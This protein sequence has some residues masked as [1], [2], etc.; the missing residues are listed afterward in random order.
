MTTQPLDDTVTILHSAASPARVLVADDHKHV[1]EALRLLLK[2]NRVAVRAVSS[3]AAVLTALR[4]RAHEPFDLLLMDLN[5]ARDTT[6]GEE[7]I[8]LLARV[9]AIDPDLPI[10]VMTAWSSVPLAVT[11]MREGAADFVEKPWDN[12]R[13]LSTVR[14]QVARG[15]QRRRARRL[16]ADAAEVQRRL[17]GMAVPRAD[18]YALGVA[19]QFCDGL[20]GD[21]YEIAPLT[22]GRL[23]VAIWD[24]SGKGTPAALLV[25]SVQ[26][27]LESLVSRGLTPREVVAELGRVVAPRLAPERFVSLVYA[28]LDPAVGRLTYANAGH[29]APVLLRADGGVKRMVRGGP[30]LGVVPDADYEEGVLALSPGDRLVLFTDGITEAAQA[31]DRGGGEELGDERLVTAVRELRPR[32]AHEAAPALIDVARRFAGHSLADDATVVV[33][34]PA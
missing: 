3:P 7:G 9:R 30:V 10:V 31:A 19:W 6:S 32:P 33:A 24:V 34:D 22:G 12:A 23:G 20:G 16:E 29:P 25:A 4:E 28:V 18:G 13:L 27:T 26:A 14:A 5:Y 8:E 2:T 21:A 11:T 1:L 17:L 15:R